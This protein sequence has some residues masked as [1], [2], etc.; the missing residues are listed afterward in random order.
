M[1]LDQF[2]VAVIGLFIPPAVALAVKYR[3][4]NDVL[5]RAL[6][7]LLAAGVAI[8]E[9]LIDDTPDTWKTVTLAALTAL[10]AS[11]VAFKT[12]GGQRLNARLAPDFG[13]GPAKD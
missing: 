2:W 5:H 6:A 4:D 1:L 10:V 9:A 7:V 3:G 13:L 8:G 12:L 11:Q